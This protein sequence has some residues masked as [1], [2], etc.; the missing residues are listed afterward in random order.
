MV[1]RETH[2]LI[3]EVIRSAESIAGADIHVTGESL[4]V[5]FY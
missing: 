2:A 1:R 5:N 4:A 3:K